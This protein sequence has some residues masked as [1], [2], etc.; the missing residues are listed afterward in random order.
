MAILKNGYIQSVVR[1]TWLTEQWKEVNKILGN[2]GIKH[3]LLK[4]MAL[5]H[6]VYDAKGLR[7]MNDNDI[8]VKRDDA[9]KAWFL[10][11]QEGFSY[12]LIKSPL[13]KNIIVDIDKHL[14]CL[15]KNG[16]PIEIHHKLFNNKIL[17]K[18]YNYDIFDDSVEILIDGT[19]AWILSKEVQQTYLLNHYERHK[20]EGNCQLRLYADIIL[21]NNI[22]TITIPN[23][24]ISDP[25]QEYKLQYRKS[26]YRFNIRSVP[27]KK[28]FLYIVGDIFPS[29]KWM[30]ERY[31][32]NGVKAFL[33]YPVRICKLLWLI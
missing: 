26:A 6:T 17:D 11:Q 31:K 2:A 24:F 13:H 7:Q 21:L 14:P 4:G 15:Y 5:E 1:N 20:L 9:L 33:H 12:E 19:K 18:K 28:R 16:Y 32:C 22:S 27:V 8:L 23:Q 29:I 3:V 30:K 10:L 25:N